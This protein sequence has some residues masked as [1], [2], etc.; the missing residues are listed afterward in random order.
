MCACGCVY[1]CEKEI[2]CDRVEGGD[3]VAGAWRLALVK[4]RTN[5]RRNH[6]RNNS[7]S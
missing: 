5:E 4:T 7:R 6:N 2:V 1:L 3:Q